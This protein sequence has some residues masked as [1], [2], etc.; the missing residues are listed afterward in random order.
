MPFLNVSSRWLSD[1]GKRQAISRKRWLTE[2]ISTVT[3]PSCQGAC[4]RPKP[5]MLRIIGDLSPSM[6]N[7]GRPDR[8]GTG[9]FWR[10]RH[11]GHVTIDVARQPSIGVSV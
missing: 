10:G 7:V 6:D 3:D 4:R 5:V 2:R 9:V 1:L 11:S 8:W